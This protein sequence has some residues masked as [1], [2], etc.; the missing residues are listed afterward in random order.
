MEKRLT[1]LLLDR[2][3]RGIP[4]VLG[5]SDVA[6]WILVDADNNLTTGKTGVDY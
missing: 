3:I 5:A 6:Y 2:E 4:S 1:R